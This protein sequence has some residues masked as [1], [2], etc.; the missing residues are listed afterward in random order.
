MYRL[1]K[2]NLTFNKATDYRYP[3]WVL[4]IIFAS[5]VVYVLRFTPE[6]VPKGHERPAPVT[7]SADILLNDSAV[8]MELIRVGCVLPNVALAQFKVETGHFKSAIC[9]ENKNLAGIR[10]SAS[11][12][13]RG[14]S[15]GHNVYATYKDCISD[16]VRIQNAY[17]MKID[18]KYAEADGYI[19]LIRKVR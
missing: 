8:M 10:N 2:K 17:L 4:L 12:L 11:S 18:G 13:S 15:R 3:F 6:L 14:F 1:D 5:F 9:L 19:N 7:D 16:Y